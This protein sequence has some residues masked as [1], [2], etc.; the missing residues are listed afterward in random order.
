MEEGKNSCGGLDK[1]R[2]VL[3]TDSRESPILPNT[4]DRLSPM[5]NVGQGQST[6]V[7]CS[8]DNEFRVL[9]RPI[10]GITPLAEPTVLKSLQTLTDAKLVTAKGSGST[11]FQSASGRDVKISDSALAKA[12][13]IMSEAEKS[14]VLTEFSNNT[15]AKEKS[16]MN[17]LVSPEQTLGLT[18]KEQAIV[19]Q[20]EN[21][22]S[23]GAFDPSGKLLDS[24]VMNTTVNTVSTH[25]QRMAYVGFQCSSVKTV[26]PSNKALQKAECLMQDIVKDETDP[27]VFLSSGFQSASGKEITPSAV[28]QQKALKL[29]EETSS[30]DDSSNLHSDTEKNVD[31]NMN[32]HDSITATQMREI[33]DSTSAFLETELGFSQQEGDPE[34]V[35]NFKSVQN[36][37]TSEQE[38]VS[39][40][41]EAAKMASENVHT[42]EESRYSITDD[43]LCNIDCEELERLERSCSRQLSRPPN[44]VS[45]SV[46]VQPVGTSFAGLDGHTSFVST[47][48]MENEK[49]ILDDTVP[50]VQSSN[51][52]TNLN[53]NQ[54]LKDKVSL[55]S[56]LF[57]TA[58][59][60]DVS[61]S[62]SALESAEHLKEEAVKE[63][64]SDFAVPD[65]ENE[66]VAVAQQPANQANGNRV[67]TDLSCGLKLPQRPKQKSHGLGF[68]TAKGNAVSVSSNTLQAARKMLESCD[69]TDMADGQ[70]V[71]DIDHS[72]KKDEEVIIVKPN[73]RELIA[74]GT[75]MLST[76]R[77][78]V[79]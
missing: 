15:E 35:F 48:F 52:L 11:L 56:A 63:Q 28:A 51:M 70:A 36:A 4:P 22:E 55:G 75:V 30:F 8:S 50:E 1:P 76:D 46:D 10:P 69:E 43:S 57:Q 49:N 77:K 79:V 27:L 61:I 14:G 40:K 33:V 34:I 9:K 19:L 31:I 44:Q 12:E 42:S 32:S 78:S 21:I 41:V 29:L 71:P 64:D 13:K 37:E 54:T 45:T 66:E 24:Y 20:K 3:R 39:I 25:N 2:K 23:S 7:S 53:K 38:T 68:I 17:K 60:K 26:S 16:H 6:P 5:P 18:R 67:V 58:S 62:S 72:E 73:D 47:D 59:G 65:I 74:S